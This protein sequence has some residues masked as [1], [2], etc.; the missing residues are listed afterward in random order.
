MSATFI[1]FTKAEVNAELAKKMNVA[2][3]GTYATDEEAAAAAANAVT[4]AKAT[5]EE[6]Q[7]AMDEVW[8]PT[9][10]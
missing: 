6:V 9:E 2:D 4:N 5:D 1:Y 7:A 10:G 8:T 3:M